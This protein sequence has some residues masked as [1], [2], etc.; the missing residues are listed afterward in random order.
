MGMNKDRAGRRRVR[1]GRGG[2]LAARERGLREPTS[3]EEKEG[4]ESEKIDGRW[5]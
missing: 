4:A 2:K 1:G 3:G 5:I